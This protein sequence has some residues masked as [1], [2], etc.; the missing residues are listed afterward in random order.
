MNSNINILHIFVNNYSKIENNSS[1]ILLL[2]SQEQ[3]YIS[4]LLISIS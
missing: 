2:R 1:I 3:D 4:V